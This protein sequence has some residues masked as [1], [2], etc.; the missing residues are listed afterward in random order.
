MDMVIEDCRAVV[1]SGVIEGASVY[2][3]DGIIEEVSLSAIRGRT[4]RVQADGLYL[5]PGF[6]D[7]HSDAIEREISPRPNVFFPVNIALFELD[8]RLATSGITT[9]F[10]SLSFSEGEIGIRSNRTVYDIIKEINRLKSAFSINTMVHA[11]YEITDDGAMAYLK[12]LMRDRQINLLSIMDHTPGQGQFRE[13][14]SYK[15]YFGNMYNKTEA[16]LDKIIEQKMESK[17]RV[18]GNVEELIR[19]CRQSGVPMASHDDDSPEKMGWLKENGIDISEFPVNMEAL[20]AAQGVGIKVCLGAPNVLRG[21]SQANNLSARDA[22]INGRGDILC[23]D[24]TPMTMLHAV[25]T[26][27][28]L[29]ILPLSE[30]VKMTSLNPARAVGIGIETGSIEEGK[31]A[32]MILVDTKDEVP[33]VIRTFVSGNEVY[34]GT[35]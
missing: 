21:N 33:T 32:D 34:R 31:K 20:E 35:R 14:A 10:H 11:R 25:F 15:H 17:G 26:L 24:Y 12:K 1:P 28:D 18:N 9:I 19:T 22:I 30:A 2:I 6:V 8:K 7:I 27:V 5:L 4:K 23:S 29:N 16:E 13:I 3:R